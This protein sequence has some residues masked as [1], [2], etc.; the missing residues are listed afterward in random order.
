MTPSGLSFMLKTDQSVCFGYEVT[1]F[2][3][4][5]MILVTGGAGHIGNTLVRQLV[6]H[7]QQV[8]ALVLPGEDTTS[9]KGVDVEVVK[10]DVLDL[11]SLRLA[12]QGV[13]GVFHL[14]SLIWIMPGRN[15]LVHRVNVDGTR[16]ILQA[17]RECGVK[18][19][20]YTS[21]IH[22]IRRMPDGVTIDESIPFDPHSPAGFYDQTKAEATLLVLEAASQGLDAVVVC[23]TGVIGPND[24]RKSEM[25]QLIAQWME[26]GL[27][28]LIDG[29]F[30]FVDVRDVARGHIQAYENGKS[31]E[32]YILSGELISLERIKELVQQV[33]GKFSRLWMVP[34]PLARFVARLTPYWYRLSHTTPRFTPY[35]IETV[36]DNAC[37][38][39]GKARREL[40]YMPRALTE[41]ITDTVAWWRQH[42]GLLR[43]A[44]RRA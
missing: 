14:A 26:K 12:M 2:L 34:L 9:L 13:E 41:T 31:G 43:L 32:T 36:R 6:E 20:V 27:H 25:G 5:N 7:G 17:V 33:T 23:P 24:F 37:I 4:K 35:S 40:G 1:F 10:G 19:L 18:R 15:E 44:G 39:C 8:R 11:D 3:E 16:N 30:D 38:S 21:S 42:A 29:L 28:V 22:A